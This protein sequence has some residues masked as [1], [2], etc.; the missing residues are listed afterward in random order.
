MY[1]KSDLRQFKRLGIKPEQVDKQLEHFANGF[2]HV[3]LKETAATGNGIKQLPEQEIDNLVS[4]FREKQPSLSMIKM[5]PASGSA[6]RMFKVLNTFMTTYTGSDA[7]YLQLRRDKGPG[8]PLLFFEKIREYPFFRRLREVLYKDHLDIDKL[9]RKN[10]FIEILEYLLTEK[11]LNYNATPKGLIDFHLYQEHVRTAFEEH[12]VEGALYCNNGKTANLHF[13]VSRE[14]A[15][16]FKALLKS[17]RGRYEKET[18]TRFNVSFSIQRRD[19]DTVSLARDNQLLRDKNQTIVF[20]PGGH[21]ALIHNLNDLKEEIIFIKNIDNVTPDRNKDVTVRYK[22]AL[23]GLLLET[24][25]KVFHY[26]R[27]LDRRAVTPALLD[28]VEAFIREHLGHR[29]PALS[30]DATR[31][32]RVKCLKRVLDRPL[33][34]CGMVRNEGEPGGGPFWVTASDGGE[35][36]M[37]VESAQVNM[38]DKEQKGI[39]LASTHFNPVDIVC[40]T[41]DYK[42]R[43]YNLLDFIDERQGFITAKSFEG[44]EIRVQEL[45]GLWNGAMAN[46]NTLFV[47]VPLAT[48]TPVKTVFD[49]LR[50][51]HMNVVSSM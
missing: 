2:D 35:R 49:L 51:E 27:L 34:V 33:R 6:T 50:V 1:T 25:E 29:P 48:F 42:G 30:P 26:A 31:K 4:R 5:V 23:G 9:S 13:T 44:E 8:T 3:A 40:S 15:S 16:R 37:I 47:E 17:V 36:L 12:L 38:K 19:T 41:R 10:Q 39:F 11:G 22:Q 28:E 14:H 32:E 45:P 24:R 21:G 43:R 46:W 20:R 18:G 7:E